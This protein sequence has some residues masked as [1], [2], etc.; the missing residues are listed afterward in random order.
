M[1]SVNLIVFLSSQRYIILIIQLFLHLSLKVG[2]CPPPDT[3]FPYSKHSAQLSLYRYFTF[4]E[5]TK[6]TSNTFFKIRKHSQTISNRSRTV[7]N[8]DT[9][10]RFQGRSPKHNFS[11][12]S[13]Q[14]HFQ[15]SDQTP[16]FHVHIQLYF[17]DPEIFFFLN[18]TC[19]YLY[20]VHFNDYGHI[21]AQQKD[22][23]MHQDT[24]VRGKWC[25]K[26]QTG[27]L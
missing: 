21:L 17:T 19:T 1:L 10:T 5:P 9:H 16:K 6:Q 26:Q 8:T 14:S 2:C 3:E 23:K 13:Y 7:E 12:L 11:T 15:H 27:Q 18:N 22:Q 4:S 25:P 24:S 20:Y